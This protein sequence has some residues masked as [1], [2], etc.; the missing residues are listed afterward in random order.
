MFSYDVGA[1]LW[2]LVAEAPRKKSHFLRVSTFNAPMVHRKVFSQVSSCV[3]VFSIP[4]SSVG[5]TK[6]GFGLWWFTLSRTSIATARTVSR[7]QTLLPGRRLYDE[8]PRWFLLCV[9]F[10]ITSLKMRYSM[11]YPIHQEF[12]YRAEMRERTERLC[13]PTGQ[14]ELS[15]CG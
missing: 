4:P 15:R 2:S 14:Q 13:P 8:C 1:R 11:N 3:V 9:P 7:D 12:C 10:E 5:L 6:I